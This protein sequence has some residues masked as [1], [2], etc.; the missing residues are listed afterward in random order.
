MRGDGMTRIDVTQMHIDDAQRYRSEPSE[1]PHHCP[2]AQAARDA[3]ILHPNVS[4]C[5]LRY[6][7]EDGS[8]KRVGLPAAAQKFIN[9]FDNTEYYV[10]PFAFEVDMKRGLSL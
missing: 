3:G 2:V 7:D 9:T 6:K 4:S 1:L 10:E 8:I 5:S